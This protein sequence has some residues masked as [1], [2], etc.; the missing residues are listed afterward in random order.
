MKEGHR[1]RVM[2]EG[3][4]EI[5]VARDP[6]RSSVELQIG[7]T[8]A[9]GGRVI[10]LSREEARRLAALILFHAAR[11]DRPHAGWGLAYAEPERQSA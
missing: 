2:D 1:M 11:L 9:D 5:L 6:T 8:A 7:T 10:H 3:T 4:A